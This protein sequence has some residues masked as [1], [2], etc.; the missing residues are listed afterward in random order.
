MHW[1]EIYVLANEAALLLMMIVFIGIIVWAYA[2]K[3]RDSL[4]KHA[5]IPLRND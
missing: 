5:D 1:H 2:P 4:Q 3:R